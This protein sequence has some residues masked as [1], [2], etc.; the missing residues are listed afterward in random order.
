MF[1]LL[2]VLAAVFAAGWVMRKLRSFGPDQPGGLQ[3]VAQ[4]AL[5]TKERAVIVRV[6]DV[7]VLVGVAP[8]RVSALHTWT[9]SPQESPVPVSDTQQAKVQTP[10][11]QELLKK[12]LGM[13]S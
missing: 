9:A 4:V 3:V 1:A 10:S 2:I 13:K 7:H 6:H 11:F 12:S 8:G 5:G